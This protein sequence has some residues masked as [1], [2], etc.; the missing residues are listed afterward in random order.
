MKKWNGNHDFF[1]F[2][3]PKTSELVGESS[4]GPIILERDVARQKIYSYYIIMH[5]SKT[6]VKLLILYWCSWLLLIITWWGRR[7]RVLLLKW[8]NIII[9]TWLRRELIP[10]SQ[11]LFLWLE[12]IKGWRSIIII[13]FSV[14]HTKLCMVS[15]AFPFITPIFYCLPC[16]WWW[17]IIWLQMNLTLDVMSSSTSTFI[18]FL[19]RGLNSG[20]YTSMMQIKNINSLRACLRVLKRHSSFF[21]KKFVLLRM[22][23]VLNILQL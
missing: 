9:L 8:I 13:I 10:F 6:N 4:S 18:L 20:Y 1:P 15:V 2:E 22:P 12:G 19:K 21:K 23:L 17:I 14:L 5:I 3:A 7:W 11:L 16:S